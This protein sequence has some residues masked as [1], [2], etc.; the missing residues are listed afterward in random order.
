M[1][2][3]GRTKQVMFGFVPKIGDVSCFVP[4]RQRVLLELWLDT[5]PGAVSAFVF[6]RPRVR[7]RRLLNAS[8]IELLAF[9]DV[10]N[11]ILDS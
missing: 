1:A 11:G 4:K 7:Q 10:L 9:L 5:S 3:T 6:R 8:G 2:A